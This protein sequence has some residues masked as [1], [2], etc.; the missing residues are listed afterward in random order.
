MLPDRYVI[1]AENPGHA[2]AT[3]EVVLASGADLKGVDLILAP[4]GVVSG[5]VVSADG[6]AV[7]GATVTGWV[8]E[9]SA[10]VTSPGRWAS[11]RTDAGGGFRLTSLAAGQLQIEVHEADQ[12]DATYGPEPLAAG[13]QKVVKL[14]LQSGA[15]VSGKVFWKGADRQPA[16]GV[17][18][19]ALVP[20][21]MNMVQ[22]T[23]GPDGD[24]RL[25]PLAPG[26]AMVAASRTE[27]MAALAE[28]DPTATRKVT[29]AG[30]EQKRGVNLVVE[31]GGH[32]LDGIVLDPQ[33]KP[34]AGARV[35]ADVGESPLRAMRAAFGGMLGEKPVLSGEDGRFV[36]EDLPA[37]PY[38]VSAT[39]TGHP[40]A[41]VGKVSTDARDVRLQFAPAAV[42]AGVAADANGK[43]I[44]DFTIAAIESP[45]DSPE[46]MAARAMRSMSS[47]MGNGAPPI[48]DP[49]GAFEVSGLAAGTYDLVVSTADGKIG[50]LAAVAVAAGERKAGLRVTVKMGTSLKGKLV[51]F[52]AGKPVGG[53][54]VVVMGD[55][56]PVMRTSGAD[57][58]F[59]V[60]GLAAGGTVNLAYGGPMTGFVHDSREVKIPAAATLVDLGAIRLLRGETGPRSGLRA[61]GLRVKTADGSPEITAVLRGGA[62]EGAGIKSGERIAAVDGQPVDGLGENSLDHLV[63]RGPGKPV[64]ISLKSAGGAELRK[65]PLQPA[66]QAE[67]PER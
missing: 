33:G 16:A 9:S 45:S 50:R 18:V 28:L 22:A 4:E 65:V 29:L 40:G 46:K 66:P 47:L 10:G 2:T 13:E 59:S 30:S 61:L 1:S 32:R 5:T 43:P 39:A 49:S 52:P 6:K 11:D 35:T 60:E 3:R 14:T 56:Q 44:P 12:G 31:K 27:G 36:I 15:T 51:D 8:L 24:Y 57:G 53:A 20:G 34:L 19:F 25:G 26:Q 21:R 42:L 62:A 48:H 37:G 58:S 54:M 67:D 64:E 63:D 55:R 17:H 23:T 7:A 41:S 38:T